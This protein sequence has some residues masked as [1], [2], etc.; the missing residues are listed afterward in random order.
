MWF[1]YIGGYRSIAGKDRLMGLRE[2][3]SALPP[4]FRFYPSDEELVCFYLRNKVANQ[5]VPSGTLVEVDLHAREPWELP[6]NKQALDLYIIIV[7]HFLASPS[8][9]YRLP[10]RPALESLALKNFLTHIY[11]YGTTYI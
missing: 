9:I 5:R 11:I 6:G 4:G 10:G 7:M 3:D 1:G 8:F 2:M